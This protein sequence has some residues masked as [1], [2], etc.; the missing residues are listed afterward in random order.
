MTATMTGTDAIN[1]LEQAGWDTREAI[2]RATDPTNARSVVRA[3]L[4]QRDQLLAPGS[5]TP[6]L[7]LA[8]D[9]LYTATPTALSETVRWWIEA[10]DRYT[11]LLEDGAVLDDDDLAD[12]FD[13]IN[14]VVY[15]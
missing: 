3:A 12:L 6:L 2:M 14:W 15:R 11:A 8:I 13:S 7:G 9:D 10:Y 5:E 4:H 1:E